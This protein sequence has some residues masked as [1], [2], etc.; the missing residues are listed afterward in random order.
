MLFMDEQFH[1]PEVYV[2]LMN[3]TYRVHRYAFTNSYVLDLELINNAQNMMYVQHAVHESST[4][5][6]I[7]KIRIQL[8]LV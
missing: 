5:V 1:V 2:H 6:D 4:I 8:L 7:N 3:V